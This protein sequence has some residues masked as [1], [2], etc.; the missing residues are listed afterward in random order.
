MDV[1]AEIWKIQSDVAI[2]KEGLQVSVVE[3]GRLK[4][5]Q[6]SL[7]GY[8][9]TLGEGM[10]QLNHNVGAIVEGI[11]ELNI[12][13]DKC[14]DYQLKLTENIVALRDDMSTLRT[15]M[16]EDRMYLR[17]EMVALKADVLTTREEMAAMQTEMREGFTQLKEEARNS[18]KEMREDMAAM[19][20]MLMRSLER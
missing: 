1:D 5:D 4:V 8:A 2:L 7:R 20:E 6:G 12:E 19:K 18:Q 15:D 10:N 16:R 11:K 9:L 17:G 13:V 3:V 14:A